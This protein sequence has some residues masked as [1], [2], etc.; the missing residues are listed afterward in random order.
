METI[1]SD[2]AKLLGQRNRSRI[3]EHL[4]R[5]PGNH[6]RAI[7]RSLGVSRGTARYHLLVLTREGL[8][9]SERIGG[10]CRYFAQRDVGQAPTN[11]FYR[12][13]WRRRDVRGRVW[14]AVLRL[15][16]PRPS[17][18][19]AMIGV[20]RQLAA[21]HLRRLLQMRLV[22]THK[23]HYRPLQSASADVEE[24]RHH[25]PT[26][27]GLDGAL[28]FGAIGRRLGITLRPNRSSA[29]PPSWSRL[30]EEWADAP[31]SVDVGSFASAATPSQ[32]I[33]AG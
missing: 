21:Y 28:W 29:S 10:R 24:T 12:R 18:V 31:P 25:R 33:A 20:S 5:V 22:A 13:Y 26:R 2:Q 7:A 14:A 17:A 1:A 3:L 27:G 4:T 9:R 30:S 19:A 15:H 16:D 11:E 23:G 8:V 32:P 6:F